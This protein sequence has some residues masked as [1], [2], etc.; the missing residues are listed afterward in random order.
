MQGNGS[1]EMVTIRA[2]RPLSAGCTGT[3]SL[4][5][6][7]RGGEQ[8]GAW[9]GSLEHPHSGV[10]GSRLLELAA[11][12]PQNPL[13]PQDPRWMGLGWGRQ[14]L[15]LFL[16]PRQEVPKLSTGLGCELLQTLLFTPGNRNT[17][18]LPWCTH[19]AGSHPGVLTIHWSDA[20]P[21]TSLI[22]KSVQLSVTQAPH[23]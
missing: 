11:P 2:G 15:P 4:L 7:G 21:A 16:A 23:L 22:S 19:T 3:H 5:P 6:G 20:V 9:K 13:K 8:W 10:T 1:V 12:W 18:S 14:V 17:P